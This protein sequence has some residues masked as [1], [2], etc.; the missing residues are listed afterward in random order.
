MFTPPSAPFGLF[1]RT[2]IAVCIL[3]SLQVA[4][5]QGTDVPVFAD[6]FNEYTAGAALPASGSKLWGYS[7]NT[8]PFQTIVIRDSSDVFGESS[9]NNCLLMSAT[10]AGGYYCSTNCISTLILSGSVSFNFFQPTV[11]TGTGDGLFFRLGNGS[12]GNTSVAFAFGM[13]N[14]VLYSSTDSGVN[15]SSSSFATYSLNQKHSLT[16]YFN[17]SSRKCISIWSA[18]RP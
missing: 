16:V 13:K 14:G 6:N 18:A 1:V 8:A 4:K 15:I 12:M 10:A 7:D 5:A 2:I 17:N 11:A 9:T 3:A